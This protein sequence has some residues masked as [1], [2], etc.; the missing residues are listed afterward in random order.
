M[1]KSLLGLL[2][3]GFLFSTLVFAQDASSSGGSM[4]QDSSMGAKKEK[5]PKAQNIKGTISDDGKSFTADKDKKSWNIVNPEAVK[6]HEGHHVVLN[7][8]VYADKGEIHVMSVKMMAD[9]GKK[10]SK[11]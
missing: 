7:A 6:G 2:V 3:F 5:A 11:M 10:D 8:H 9:K 4:G 1:K